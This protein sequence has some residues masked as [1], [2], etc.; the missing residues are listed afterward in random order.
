MN[1][2]PYKRFYS[3]YTEKYKHSD[4]SI[5]CSNGRQKWCGEVK[6][7]DNPKI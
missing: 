1:C 4:P 3:S 5:I 6:T 2:V 7:R